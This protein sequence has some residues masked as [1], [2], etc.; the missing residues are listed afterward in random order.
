MA[1]TSE[2]SSIEYSG[3]GSAVTAYPVPFRFVQASHLTVTVT[4]SG[5]AVTI[6]APTTGFVA[7]GAGDESG[8]IRTVAA[9]PGSSTLRIERSVPFTQPNVYSVGGALP[10]KT[11]EQNFDLI[12]MQVQRVWRAMSNF[13]AD[14]ALKANLASPALTGIP[15]APTAA[16]GTNSNQLATTAHVQAVTSA[17]AGFGTAE[18]SN[19]AAKFAEQDAKFAE[20][21]ATFAAND[22]AH[23]DF[24]TA[25]ALKLSKASNLSDIT[26]AA[27]ARTNLGLG[28]MATSTDAANLTGTL[29]MDR[30][31]V[32]AI[33]TAKVAN[34]AITAEKLSGAQSGVAPIFG[35]RAWVNFDATKNSAGG[36][37]ALNT[38]RFIRNSGNVASVKKDASG[39]YLITYSNEVIGSVAV[40]GNFNVGSALL[41]A[42]NGGQVSAYATSNT[43]VK[44]SLVNQA[45]AFVNPEVCSVVIFG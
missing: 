20:Q 18:L 31:A 24:V 3:N 44:I 21:D 9:V 8:S 4:A 22:S 17:L 40:A 5:G 35:A 12:V 29:S 28:A 7:S 32:G 2:T 16:T 39:D 37:D 6:L 41:T 13:I 38:N 1:I 25:D 45:S 43:G 33:P 15:T 27:T 14:L 30:V 34:A 11:L 26:S 10:P 19:A 36:T 42:N 23:A